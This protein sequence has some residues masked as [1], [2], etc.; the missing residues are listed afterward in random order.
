MVMVRHQ[1]ERMDPQIEPLRGFPQ[2][3]KKSPA[4]V[5]IEARKHAHDST[6]PVLPIGALAR[7]DRPAPTLTGYDDLLEAQ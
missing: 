1:T 2:C 7:F 5:V 4:V 3:V 6:A